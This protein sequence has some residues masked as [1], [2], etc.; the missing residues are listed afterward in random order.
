MDPKDTEQPSDGWFRELAERTGDIFYAIRTHPDFAVEFISDSISNWGGFSQAD[1]LGDPST[2]RAILDPRDAER[3]SDVLASPPGVDVEFEFRWRHRDGRIVWTQ[4]WGRKRERADG[5]VVMEGTAHDITELKRAQERLL[6]SRQQLRWLLDNVADAIVQFDADA[7]LVWASPSLRTLF[8][9]DPADVVGTKFRLTAPEDQERTSAAFRRAKE[10]GQIELHHRCRA[11]TG[12]G[13]IRWTETTARILHDD[14]GKYNGAVWSVRDVTSQVLV[15]Q[16]LASSREEYRLLAEQSSDFTLR[17][18]TDYIIEWVSPSVTK[19]LGWRPEELIGRSGVEFFHP[20][21]VSGTL[22]HARRMAS[23]GSASGRVRLRCADGTYRWV[24]QVARPV[25]DDHGALVAR[26]SGFQDVDAQVRAEHALARS[27]R[28]FRLA[29]ESAPTGMAVIDL[30]RRFVEVNPALCAMLERDEE[31]LL[32]HSV[33]DVVSPEDD[34]LDLELRERVRTSGTS[35]RQTHRLLTSR[36]TEVIAEHSVGVLLDDEGYPT[37]YVSQFLDVTAER[38][39]EDRLRFLAGHDA[40][41]SLANR[42]N[43]L[44][45]MTGFLTRARH[46]GTG[47]VVLFVDLD[48]FK[49][50][51]DTYGHAAGDDLL[52]QVAGRLTSHVRTDDVVSRIG[53]DEFIVALPSVR[54]ISDAEQIAHKLHTAVAEPFDICGHQVR[55]TC[56]IG[57]AVAAP[58]ETADNVLRRAD[59]ALYEAKRAGRNRSVSARVHNLDEDGVARPG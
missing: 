56:S 48:E 24:S 2:L 17:T 39:A 20:N 36:G 52:V 58:G 43:L 51:N 18:V 34:A 27:E 6:K 12:D 16:E 53:G 11:L 9:W 31:W 26:I 7:V 50:V 49:P 55:V 21:D 35:A 41:T 37:S 19:V 1:Y 32:E 29:M 13:D 10:S 33:A 46:T 8:G 59:E 57:I 5:S 4:N 45:R 25:F 44:S 14:D 22:E 40:L 28:R 3:V 54:D 38:A 30:D 15:E 42:H 23:G 47:L